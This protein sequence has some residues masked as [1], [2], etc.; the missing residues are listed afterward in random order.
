LGDED[1]L[2]FTQD[3]DGDPQSITGS[4]ILPSDLRPMRLFTEQRRRLMR[5]L[6]RES[7]FFHPDSRVFEARLA[8]KIPQVAGS[9]DLDEA[10]L[11]SLAREERARFYELHLAICRA[12]A[13]F[14]RGKP[15]PAHVPQDVVAEVA[16]VAYSRMDHPS[17]KA[18]ALAFAKLQADQARETFAGL[19]QF[20]QDFYASRLFSFIKRAMLRRRK[21]A[22]KDERLRQAVT[23]LENARQVYR[24]V[25][26]KNQRL[27]ELIDLRASIKR[28]LGTF[29]EQEVCR[30]PVLIAL[31][32]SLQY[33]E[34]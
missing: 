12:S 6:I 24:A 13:A 33:L 34:R 20:M 25:M 14:V 21:M 18:Q 28:L 9:W 32:K 7:G 3:P 4:G 16:S 2:F 8:E 15:A 11:L 23:L 10:A 30:V 17:Y 5:T 29:V 22:G 26:K 1:F 27:D 31:K 19:D